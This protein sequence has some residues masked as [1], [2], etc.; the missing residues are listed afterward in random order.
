MLDK[1]IEFQMG[2]GCPESE[3]KGI[4]NGAICLPAKKTSMG[5][6]CVKVPAR[7]RCTGATGREN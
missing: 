4:F 2:R 1:L 7:M 6:I 5:K 3:K